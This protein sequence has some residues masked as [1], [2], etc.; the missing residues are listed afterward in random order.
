MSDL[1]VSNVPHYVNA[2]CTLVPVGE[3]LVIPP[4]APTFF[5]FTMALTNVKIMSANNTT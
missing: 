4:G 3:M 2:A 1:D 5:T